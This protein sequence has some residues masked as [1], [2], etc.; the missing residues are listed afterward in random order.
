MRPRSRRNLSPVTDR[1]LPEEG[2]IWEKR[3]T[4]ERFEVWDTS[5]RWVTIYPLRAGNRR[6]V[7]VI[8]HN[9]FQEYVR[10]GEDD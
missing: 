7:D 9:F 6:A 3:K 1:E 4:G 8:T 5:P 10:V 2:E